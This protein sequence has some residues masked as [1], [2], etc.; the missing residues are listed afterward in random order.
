MNQRPTRICDCE[1][2]NLPA[3]FQVGFIAP[4]KKLII[5]N[6]AGGKEFQMWLALGVCGSC[7][8]KIKTV[9]QLITEKDMNSTNAKM[10]AASKPPVDFA[11][12]F[13]MFMEVVDGKPDV[14]KVTR[15]DGKPFEHK[16][17]PAGIIRG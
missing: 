17:K 9:D 11:N 7:R 10:A 1:G 6:D 8:E 14:T 16:Y 5:L 13:V 3:R 4:L 15:A 12:G 2:C